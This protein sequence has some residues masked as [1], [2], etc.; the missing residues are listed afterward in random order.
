VGIVKELR[1]PADDLAEDLRLRSFHTLPRSDFKC[2]IPKKQT[3]CEH[4]GTVEKVSNFSQTSA[5]PIQSSDITKHKLAIQ[6]SAI[7][8]NITST[9]WQLKYCFLSLQAIFGN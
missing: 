8:A 5:V 7:L 2:G 4:A 3:T 1:N 9:A 6:R